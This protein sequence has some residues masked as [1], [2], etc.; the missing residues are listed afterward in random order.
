MFIQFDNI[1]QKKTAIYISH[2][3]SSCRLCDEIFV[4][5]Q[6]EICEHGTHEEL[7]EQNKEYSKLYSLQAKYYI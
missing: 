1:V 4:F 2:R 3:L 7:I 5:K 6:G